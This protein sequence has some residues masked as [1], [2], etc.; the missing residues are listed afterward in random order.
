MM[1]YDTE[2]TCTKNDDFTLYSR[3]MNHDKGLVIRR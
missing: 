1:F 3:K 2:E